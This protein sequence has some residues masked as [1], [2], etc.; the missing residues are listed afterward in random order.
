MHP[1]RST[2]F[3][4]L[5]TAGFSVSM[6]PPRAL[7]ISQESPPVARPKATIVR[8]EG[9]AIAAPD[10]WSRFSPVRP[11]NMLYLVGDGMK[12][13]PRVDGSL[14]ALKVGLTVEVFPAQAGLTPVRRAERDLNDLKRT[15]ELEI[16]AKPEIAE[17]ELADGTMAIRLKVAV[18]KPAQRRLAFY[19]KVYCFMP[20]N[21][22]VVAT[23]FLTCGS[24]GGEFV[25]RVGL[26]QFIETHAESIVLDAEK[27]GQARWET[28][29]RSLNVR[30]GDALRKAQEGNHLLE[31][32]ANDQASAAFRAALKICDFVP[33][34]H[35][36]LAWALLQGNGKNDEHEAL[37]H[38]EAAVKLTAR[39]DSAALDTLALAYFRKNDRTQAIATIR[40][41]LKLDPGNRDLMRA[42]EKYEKK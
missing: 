32:N 37:E 7:A 13:I 9:W 28:A 25:K 18:A 14:S 38:A 41:A 5:L 40:E 29:Y 30:V 17:I 27:L 23:G 21:R 11:P 1:A 31:T 42:Q 35:N 36:G 19:S 22:Q 6:F 15:R 12:G 2:A 34:A 10:D 20:D 24:G 8:G 26:T 3:A 16:D 39:H 33:A 4:I